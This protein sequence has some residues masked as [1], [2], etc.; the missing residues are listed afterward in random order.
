V[1]SRRLTA[2]VAA[3]GLAACGPGASTVAHPTAGSSSAAPVASAPA[4][5]RVALLEPVSV[6][7]VDVAELPS[8][9][10]MSVV[11]RPTTLVELRVVVGS[12]T[13]ADGAHPG[14]AELAARLVA[15]TYAKEAKADP[16][17]AA[18]LAVN[19]GPDGA[20]F[21]GTVPPDGLAPTLAA[22]GKAM[23]KPE[24]DIEAMR[25]TSAELT[26]SVGQRARNVETAPLR[27]SIRDLYLAPVG[28]HPYSIT[29][30]SA[31]EIKG[32][33]EKSVRS[34]FETHY[35]ARN[36][37]VI[38]VGPVPVATVMSNVSE[39]F[40]KVSVGTV[41]PLSLDPP[42][43]RPR[44][45]KIML[46]DEPKRDPVI[47]GIGR[48]GP[49]IADGNASASRIFG[50]ISRDRIR[51]KAGGD[52]AFHLVPFRGGPSVAFLSMRIP[53]ARVADAVGYLRTEGDAWSKE[54]AANELVIAKNEITG[55]LGRTIDSPPE[56]AETLREALAGGAPETI[57]EREA[58]EVGTTG[59][60]DVTAAAR[61]ALSKDQILVAIG[62][63]STVGEALRV[64]GEV[65]VL[66]PAQGFNR[67]RSLAKTDPN[68]PPPPAPPP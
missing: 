10:H 27:F 34:Y 17:A 53:A 6:P 21:A 54:P 62:D 40:A 47:L 39:A 14:I 5:H 45:L 16:R 19:V 41:A 20:S 8:E 67:V 50:T 61:D 31:D 25:K 30:P 36:V 51:A 68:A 38:A 32:V 43:A 57:L 24:T 33:D 60:S 29:L 63:A 13:A 58:F 56:L 3:L 42:D 55:D 65:D 66:D 35:V 48:L 44:P 28:R 1:R 49:S 15:R 52:G 22:L 7:H 2:L 46:V 18:S 4:E 64:L 9:V 12:G 37:S 59:A 23:S 26:D 11:S